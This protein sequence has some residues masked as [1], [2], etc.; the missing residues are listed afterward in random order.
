MNQNLPHCCNLTAIDALAHRRDVEGVKI[1]C[2][3]CHEWIKFEAGGVKRCRLSSAEQ[4][5]HL[6]ATMRRKGHSD[7]IRRPRWVA[8]TGE[9]T[10]RTGGGE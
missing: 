9:R 2:H 10:T 7:G 6:T 5:K 3:E 4:L 1:K 8:R